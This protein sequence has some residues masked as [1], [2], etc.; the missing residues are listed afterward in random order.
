MKGEP[1]QTMTG[2]S[3][4]RWRGIRLTDRRPEKWRHRPVSLAVAALLL[5]GGAVAWLRLCGNVGPAKTEESVVAVTGIPQ[6]R[7]ECA[8]L[9]IGSE[10]GS[11]PLILD[12]AGVIR[13]PDKT[14]TAAL[15]PFVFEPVQGIVIGKPG[16]EPVFDLAA[17]LAQKWRS[18]WED[19]L[20]PITGIT[21]RGG[22]CVTVET[23]E[24]VTLEFVAEDLDR[25]FRNLAWIWRH[26]QKEGR[27]IAT[28]NLIPVRNVPVTFR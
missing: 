19:R 2:R 27:E 8:E 16:P 12:G 14:A 11:R 21:A 7:L 1:E 23:A 9:E 10:K 22:C 6:L 18:E 3:Q 17:G 26:S 13:P 15:P 4:R 25:Q 5:A 20:G 24:G 28:V